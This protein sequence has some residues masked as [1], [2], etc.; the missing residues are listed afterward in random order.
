MAIRAV[1]AKRTVVVEMSGA[2]EPAE[3]QGTFSMLCCTSVELSVWCATLW[4]CCGA[5]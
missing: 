1:V 5:W 2:D 4:E 3:F